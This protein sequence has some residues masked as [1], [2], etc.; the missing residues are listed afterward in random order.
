MKRLEKAGRQEVGE[1][2]MGLKG[3]EGMG[4][5]GRME[6]E[7]GERGGMGQDGG[8]GERAGMGGMVE[9]ARGVREAEQR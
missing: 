8:S 4:W 3:R 9:D 6:D 7:R 5:V 2:E 1:D